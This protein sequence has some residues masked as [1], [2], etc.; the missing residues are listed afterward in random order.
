MVLKVPNIN[1]IHKDKGQ[2]KFLSHNIHVMSTGRT[3]A[4]HCKDMLASFPRHNMLGHC[5]EGQIHI[6]G[7]QIPVTTKAWL[8]PPVLPDGGVSSV[9][10]GIHRSCH[11]LFRETGVLV[12]STH[13]VE[14]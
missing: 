7:E 13:T 14:W 9:I 12:S 8:T 11:M 4:A 6:L 10:E 1:N 5:W 2:A 3:V